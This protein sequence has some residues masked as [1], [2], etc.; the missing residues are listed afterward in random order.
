[1]EGQILFVLLAVFVP[2]AL[3]GFVVRAEVVD[4]YWAAGLCTVL[5]LGITLVLAGQDPGGAFSM[6]HG[7]EPY[8]EVLAAYVQVVNPVIVVLGLA[9]GILTGVW[10]GY[11]YRIANPK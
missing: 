2:A 5:S 3:W 6:I 8:V 4:H 10:T 9:G 11:R 7:H 1:M